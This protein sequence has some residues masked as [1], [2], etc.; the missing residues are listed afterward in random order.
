VEYHYTL[1]YCP[2]QACLSASPVVGSM[3]SHPRSAA[4]DTSER[5]PTCS[6]ANGQNRE[7]KVDRK[8]A[9][10][11]LAQKLFREKQASYI[12]HLERS[13]GLASTN[14]CSAPI[15][16]R[17][18][19]D[20]VV[21]QLTRENKELR[22]ALLRLRKGFFK[23]GEAAATYARKLSNPLSWRNDKKKACFFRAY[24]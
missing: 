22:E 12:Q 3:S 24:I 14:D 7:R 1:F 19:H 8:R 16:S 4:K 15:T 10:N 11:R 6:D 18:V 2:K 20:T 23:C 17:E 13:L 9:Q 5:R 21:T